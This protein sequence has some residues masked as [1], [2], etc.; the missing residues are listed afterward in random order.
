MIARKRW[1]SKSLAMLGM[2]CL[3]AWGVWWTD[4]IRQ[5]HL[6]GARLT[7]VPAWQESLGLDFLNNYYASRYWLAG[8]DVFR[9]AYGDPMQ[10][11]F[12]YP[13]ILLPLFSWC[14]LCSAGTAIRL[15]TVTLI[16]ITGFAVWRACRSRRQLGCWP[17][18]LP[19]A[20]AGMLFSAPF[21]FALERGNY[22]TAVILLLLI[23]AWALAQR[24]HIRDVAA[25][26]C[27][28]L[29]AGMKLY[30][31][32][33]LLGLLPLRRLRA[34][35]YA[36][37]SGLLIL[38]FHFWDLPQFWTNVQILIAHQ[39]PL[40]LGG[41]AP[42]VHPLSSCWPLL[43]KDTPWV[44]L[45][46][47]PG[48]WAALG[49]LAPLVLL[50]SYRIHRCA[51]PR[52]LVYPYLLWLAAAATFIPQVSVDYNLVFLPLAVIAVWDR[53][54][55]V[56]V[57]WCMAFLF[58]WAQPMAVAIGPVLLLGFKYLTLTAVAVCL[59]NRARE[60]ATGCRLA[61][62]LQLAPYKAA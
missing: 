2:A 17:A 49:L 15:W 23:A 50:V 45:A 60:Q 33:V 14:A 37:M 11:P 43:W 24:S 22:D 7:W 6:I 51:E 44:F 9:E 31:A 61:A 53:R 48:T 29:A 41:I 27:L 38:S 10:R 12:C 18:P 5:N 55:P 32:V 25:G 8:G 3:V 59:A 54:D 19:V 4:C 58:L 46:Q 16:L 52:H 42:Q 28:A 62:S 36:A 30:P 13:P 57:H 35:V 40:A 47:I 21:L 39:S 20:L 34:L 56:F 26:A 1:H